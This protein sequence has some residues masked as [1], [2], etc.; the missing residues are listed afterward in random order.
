MTYSTEVGKPAP[1]ITLNTVSEAKV[2][3]S[4]FQSKQAMILVFIY[5]DT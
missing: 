2:F 5:G 3:L 4:Q 1:A